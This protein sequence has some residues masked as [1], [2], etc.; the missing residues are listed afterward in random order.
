MMVMSTLPEAKKLFARAWATSGSAVFPTKSLQ[1][2]EQEN[3][4]FLSHVQCKDATCLREYDAVTL[5]KSVEDTWMK[6]HP[7]LPSKSE[8]PRN[9]HEW[10]TVD[11]EILRENPSEVWS[12]P[13]GLP[14]KLVIGTTAH[15]A[16]TQKLLDKYTKWTEELVTSHIR[17]SIVGEKKIMNDALEMYN[18][19]YKG[20]TAMI[21]DIRVVCPLLYASKEAHNVSFYIVNQTRGEQDL[22]DVDSDVDAILGRYEPKT[23]EQRRY[24]S[25][26]Q[27][28]FYYFIWNDKLQQADDSMNRMVIVGQDALPS[29]NYSHCDFWLKHNMTQFGHVN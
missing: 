12:R 4:S 10:L 23:P 19:S 3:R 21:S 11:G 13:E 5:V 14:V 18:K 7:D 8:N 2:T 24:I 17:H 1:E 28:L 6:P 9:R 16:S 25:A 26:I 15:A 27:Q 20:L 22:A 29:A